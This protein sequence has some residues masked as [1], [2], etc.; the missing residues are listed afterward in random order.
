MEKKE[1][2]EGKKLELQCEPFRVEVR[3]VL[4][5]LKR[6]EI[7]LHRMDACLLHLMY[8]LV[9]DEVD[10]GVLQHL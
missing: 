3:K 5:L 7:L 9:V 1:T 8:Y 2:K 6:G 10:N 4:S